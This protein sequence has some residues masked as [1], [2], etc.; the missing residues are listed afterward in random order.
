MQAQAVIGARELAVG[1][2][3]TALQNTDWSMFGNPALMSEDARSV[4]FFGVRYFGLSEIT[5]MA[6]AGSYPTKLGVMG[7]GAHRYGDDLFNES[8]LRLGY[9]HS[10]AGFHFGAIFNYSHVAFGGGYGS[11]GAFGVDV[12]L[13]A[14]VVS[15]LWIGAKTTN[16][17]Q[18]EYGSKNNEKLPREL[19]IGLS[20]QLSD[21]ALF[22]TDVVK[23]VQFPISY[24]GG[25]EVSI[26]KSLVG[27]T[28][29]TTEPL[30]FSGG[31]GYGSD[32]WAVNISVQRHEN[33]VLGYSPAIDFKVT[34]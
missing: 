30:T 14:S 1:Q 15:D 29:I 19:S 6:F 10:F 22:S 18:P 7:A 24:R 17:N 31:F 27:R 8:R 26:I 25:V 20:Y 11:A 2:A 34:W 21:K 3:T 32:L 5:D 12:G 23:D 16:I 33:R 28:G 13:A 9:K 4:S